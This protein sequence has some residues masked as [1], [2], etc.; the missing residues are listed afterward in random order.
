[1]HHMPHADA[2]HHAPSHHR[3]IHAKAI[4]RVFARVALRCSRTAHCAHA[5]RDAVARGLWPHMQAGDS[6]AHSAAKTRRRL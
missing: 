3:T 5:P 1:M 2:M 4:V 6:T